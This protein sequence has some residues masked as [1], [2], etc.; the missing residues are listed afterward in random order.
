MDAPDDADYRQAGVLISHR[1]NANI[2]GIRAVTLEAI[3]S[4]RCAQLL[5][6]LVEGYEFILSELRTDQSLDLVGEFIE[7]TAE[8]N[9]HPLM[10]QA[11]KAVVAHHDDDDDRFNQLMLAADTP[12]KSAV[13]LGSVTDLFNALLPELGTPNGLKNLAEWTASLANRAD[14]L[15]E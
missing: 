9:M 2:A 8:Q 12:Q 1:A 15:D 4:D 13:L 14:G 3:E 10:S 7:I 11:A 6:A 5:R